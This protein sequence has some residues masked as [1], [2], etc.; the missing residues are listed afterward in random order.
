MTQRYALVH[1][2]P[3]LWYLPKGFD[4]LSPEKKEELA[5]DFHDAVE[6]RVYSNFLEAPAGHPLEELKRACG[7]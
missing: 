2:K 4:K 5:K 7:E 1:S 3:V 6:D